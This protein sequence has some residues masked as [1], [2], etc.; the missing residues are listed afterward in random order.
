VPKDIRQA[1]IPICGILVLL[2]MLLFPKTPNRDEV[3]RPQG[4]KLPAAAALLLLG[5]TL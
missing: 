3:P 5:T 4:P 1:I 2:M